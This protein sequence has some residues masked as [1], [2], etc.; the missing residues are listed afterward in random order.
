MR[1]PIKIFIGVLIGIV[2]FHFAIIFKLIPYNIAWG[3]RLTNDTEMYV[4][5]SLSIIINLFLIWIL[6][7][8]GGMVSF[9]F[10]ERAVKVIL[11][12]FLILFVLNTFG[13]IIAKTNFEKFFAFVTAAFAVLLWRIINQ[14]K[15]T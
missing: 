9:Q 11:W 7:M 13:N 12:F 4:F 10:S 8:K 3:G 14:K 6:L 1:N 15:I 2:L 5:E